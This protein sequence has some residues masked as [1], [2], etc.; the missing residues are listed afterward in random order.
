MPYTHT[1]RSTPLAACTTIIRLTA[2]SRVIQ[3]GTTCWAPNIPPP[4]PMPPI[5]PMPP[6]PSPTIPIPIIPT[7]RC[8]STRHRT[9]PGI[10]QYQTSHRRIAWYRARHSTRVGR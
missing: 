9:V 1:P 6:M 3:K 10:A 4:I 8:V 2:Y 5:P 7:A